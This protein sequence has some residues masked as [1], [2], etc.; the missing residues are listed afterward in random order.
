MNVKV[1]RALLIG[2]GLVAVTLFIGVSTASA[3]TQN[4]FTDVNTG[5]W[6]HD[7]VCWMFDKGL[8]VG[9]PDGT[10]RPFNSVTRAEM[11]VFLQQLSG[12]GSLGPV[13][14]ADKLDGMDSAD[15]IPTNISFKARNG[16]NDAISG[17]TWTRVDF[18]FE[19]FDV[20]NNFANDRFTAT[21]AGTYS[22]STHVTT[23]D[24]TAGNYLS[25]QIRKNGVSAAE[26]TEY[27]G[28]GAYHGVGGST[29][30]ELAASDYVEVFVRNTS[31]TVTVL[32]NSLY[33][34]IISGFLVHE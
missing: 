23:T 2:I 32:G 18:D 24:G 12:E 13:V 7:Y 31:L 14:D 30:L 3:V 27:V 11:A 25:V 15:F 5:H 19:D 4:C 34:T 28:G 1:K 10:Y 20:G 8:T 9:Y 29:L 33:P 16:A 26:F 17:S 21:V 22:F 6:F